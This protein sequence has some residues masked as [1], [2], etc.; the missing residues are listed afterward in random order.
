MKMIRVIGQKTLYNVD[1]HKTCSVWVREG[2][3]DIKTQDAPQMKSGLRIKTAGKTM[4]GR[5]VPG[6]LGYMFSGGNNID[7]NAVNVALFSSAFSHGHGISILPI[8][9][10]RCVSLFSARKLIMPDWINSKD[11]YLAPDESNPEFEEF[12][13]DSVIFSLFHIHSNQSS[14]RNIDYK[15]DEKE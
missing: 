4:V 6:A 12:V 14:L 3:I 8:N 5:I 1:N 15:N 11:E 9:F 2:V 13:N 10:D 7:S